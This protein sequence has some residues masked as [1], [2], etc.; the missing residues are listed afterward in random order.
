MPARSASGANPAYTISPQESLK[1][2]Y[3]TV[4]TPLAFMLSTT[5]A[6]KMG[7]GCGIEK[8][9]GPN[10]ANGARAMYGVFSSAATDEI[11][12]VTGTT[13]PPMMISTWFSVISRRA[14]V[15]ALVGSVASSRLTYLTFSVPIVVGRMLN[16]F[17][18]GTPNDAAEPVV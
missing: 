15:T 2:M 9:H 3:A 12:E 7:T 13:L 17:L 5:G 18:Q 16:V 6:I 14:F 4:L 1:P 10:P 11:A 8:V